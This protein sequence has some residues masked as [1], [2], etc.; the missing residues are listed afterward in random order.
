MACLKPASGTPGQQLVVFTSWIAWNDTDRVGGSQHSAAFCRP[1]PVA[2][3]GSRCFCE[4]AHVAQEMLA[5]AQAHYY[6]A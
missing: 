3:A 1:H 5:R 2:L 4:K 6:P